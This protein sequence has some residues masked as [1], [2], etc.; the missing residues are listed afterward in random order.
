M[1]SPVLRVVGID[2]TF[3]GVKALS[4]VSLELE[5]GKIHGL[6]GENGAGK[7]T[8]INIIYGILR[9]DRGHLIMDDRECQ[10]RGPH[11]ARAYGID[12][13]P[14]E[15]TLVPSLTVADNICLGNLPRGN[16]G[17]VDS[18][19]VTEKARQILRRLG[20][21][22]DPAMPAGKLSVGEARI[23]EI[24]R[25]LTSKSRVLIMDEPTAALTDRERAQLFRVM[26]TLSDEG[27]AILFVSHILEEVATLC[28]SVTVLK[29]GIVAGT[30]DDEELC[31]AQIAEKMLGGRGRS[32]RHRRSNKR[33]IGEP[34]LEVQGLC[35][36]SKLHNIS[37]TLHRGEILGICG[38]LGAGK[39]EVARALFG[40]DRTS[41]GSIK[42][43][44][45][46]VRLMEPRDAI[47]VGIGL[48]TE[49]RRREGLFPLMSVKDNLTIVVL[50]DLSNRLS[51]IIRVSDE[52]EATGDI[53]D[54]FQIKVSDKRQ[55]ISSLSGGNQQKAILGRWFLSDSDILILDDPTKGVDV[56]GK[57]EIYNILMRAAEEGK[58]IILISSDA[59]E[60]LDLSDSVLLISGGRV[61]ARYGD[62]ELN[63]EILLQKMYEVD[64]SNSRSVDIRYEP[65]RSNGMGTLSG[66]DINGERTFAA[67]GSGRGRDTISNEK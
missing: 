53:I 14:Q 7:S 38:L 58:G 19:A 13:I 28:Q 51:G 36:P 23:V 41:A 54:R 47:R 64:T 44:G 61:A 3:P 9:P 39:T 27:V 37:F 56:G 15:L 42:V 12:L 59:G 18:E 57:F 10:M 33:R 31:V 50:R 35:T 4:N 66:D 5:Q 32:D 43:K 46:A 67:Q 63:R 49:D 24:A 40:L 21:T 25:A 16:L 22:I 55:I 52:T 48:V 30:F 2:K 62:S 11:D 1:S 29:D 60:V 34:L 65:L 20:A 17:T 45:K 6:V 26:N 8:L